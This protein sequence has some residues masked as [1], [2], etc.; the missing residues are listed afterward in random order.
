[1]AT[2]LVNDPTVSVHFS[3]PVEGVD[4]DDGQP[5]LASRHRVEAS[6]LRQDRDETLF[7]DETGEVVAGWDTELIDH[8]VWRDGLSVSFA[9]QVAR[10]A[11]HA[12]R[13]REL[14]KR[15]PQAYH[16][17]LPDEDERLTEEFTA[18]LT[19]AQMVE[20]HG[21]ARGA[22]MARLIHLELVS[23]DTPAAQIGRE[24]EESESS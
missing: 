24:V 15:Y 20:E 21:R 16:R 8:I 7:L 19:V 3:T 9:L 14:R 6:W 5:F 1:M 22:I 18:G 10:Q 2:T 23:R 11:A 17:W 13:L 12:E 4:P